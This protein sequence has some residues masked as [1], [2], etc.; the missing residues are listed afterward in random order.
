LKTRSTSKRVCPLIIAEA[1]TAP[2]IARKKMNRL[3][4]NHAGVAIIGPVA[5]WQ[6]VAD[7]SPGEEHA[8]GAGGEKFAGPPGRSK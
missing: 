4:D 3:R 7:E 5:E 6:T 8:T 1:A 2:I